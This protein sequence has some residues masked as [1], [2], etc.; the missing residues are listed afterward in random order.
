MNERELIPHLFRT[1]FRKIS[2][3]L[4]K[5]FGIEHMDAAEDI[6]SETFLPALETWPYKGIPA[7]PVAWLYAVAKNK[8]RSYLRRNKLLSEKIIPEIKPDT[9]SNIDIVLSEENINDSLLKA[10]KIYV[11]NIDIENL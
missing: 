10:E 2:S 9:I 4:S 11:V 3:V 5:L 1:E 8:T 7:N 6:T